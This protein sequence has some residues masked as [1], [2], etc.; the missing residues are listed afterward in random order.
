MFLV[1]EIIRLDKI[2]NAPKIEHPVF[3]RRSGKRQFVVGLELLDRLSDLRTG[4]LDELGLI[5]HHSAK[6]KLGQ[7][8]QITAQDGI[9]G[10]DDVVL[11]DKLPQVMT[12]LTTLEH[13]HLHVR[14]KLF[15]LTS[16]V[17]EH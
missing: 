17:V 14:R 8:V 4:I 16:P 1:T 6:R 5:Q 15:R 9:I 13:Q 7:V 11:G 3:D 2:N 10:H 12:R